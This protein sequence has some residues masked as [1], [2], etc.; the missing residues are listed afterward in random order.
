MF[1][2]ESEPIY[3]NCYA[4]APNAT[5]ELCDDINNL[6]C[7]KCST[8]QCNVDT[9]RR[10]NKCFKCSGIECFNPTLIDVTD[11]ISDCYVGINQSGESVRDC[12]SS[13][14]SCSA[15][16]PKCLTCD[17]DFCNGI[18][19]PTEERRSCIYCTGADCP[20]SQETKLC[21]IYGS[22]EH[23]E[24]I[25]DSELKVVEKGCSSSISSAN[26]T[27]VSSCYFDNCNVGVSINDNGVCVSCN[28]EN[29]PNCII[30]PLEADLASCATNEC[31]SRVLT[32]GIVERGCG[33]LLT[34]LC[35]GGDCERCTGN[36]CNTA[37][38]PANRQS[39]Y[40]C[41]GEDCVD[42]LGRTESCLGSDSTGCITIFGEGKHPCDMT[43]ILQFCV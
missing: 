22:N 26:A 7:T 15:S 16:D 21:E 37:V 17:D 34:S 43:H 5:K 11:C 8:S 27:G 10:G 30:N 23:C 2:D 14:P 39:C 19:F 33:A 18:A 24:T 1:N 35:S 40:K 9:K 42:G 38:I 28:S 13:V 3:R 31:Y 41:S 29:D 32:N 25:Y 12:A 4:D 6:E 36:R 20:S